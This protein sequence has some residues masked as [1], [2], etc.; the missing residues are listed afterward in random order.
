MSG[1]H[2]VKDVLGDAEI[3]LKEAKD[4]RWLSHNNAVQSLCHTLPSVVASLEREAA[5]RGEPMAIGLAR[6]INTYQFI[7]SLYL[8]CDVLQALTCVS[9]TGGRFVGCLVTSEC[10]N[11]PP[12][13]V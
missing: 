1:L 12:Q 3:N 13:C 6:M 10:Y 4:V 9:A 2:V 11:G 5:E 8:F 7:A